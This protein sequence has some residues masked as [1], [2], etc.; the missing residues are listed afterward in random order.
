MLSVYMQSVA[1]WRDEPYALH[2]RRLAPNE[3]YASRRD[4]INKVL[5]RTT[6][7][8]GAPLLDVATTP[9]LR[10]EN[11]LIESVEHRATADEAIDVYTLRK[12]QILGTSIFVIYGDNTPLSLEFENAKTTG[13]YLGTISTAPDFQDF[14]LVEVDNLLIISRATYYR[15]WTSIY[16]VVNKFRDVEKVRDYQGDAITFIDN[17]VI[18]VEDLLW[19]YT[20]TSEVLAHESE[21]WVGMRSPVRLLSSDGRFVDDNFVGATLT[22][23]IIQPHVSM[24]L[25]FSEPP[26]ID[27]NTVLIVETKKTVRS[28]RCVVPRDCTSIGMPASGEY[29]GLVVRV[30]LTDSTLTQLDILAF[31]FPF[32]TPINGATS[33]LTMPATLNLDFVFDDDLEQSDIAASLARHARKQ[34]IEGENEEMPPIPREPVAVRPIG[35]PLSKFNLHWGVHNIDMDGGLFSGSKLVLDRPLAALLPAKKK[36]R[37]HVSYVLDRQPHKHRLKFKMSDAEE[38]RSHV[39]ELPGP[40]RLHLITAPADDGYLV[41]TVI[42]D[43]LREYSAPIAASS[44]A[45]SDHDS[46]E[47]SNLLSED[48]WAS[49]L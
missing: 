41:Q 26:T 46:S 49:F 33:L 48:D 34:W 13:V 16:S 12:G 36:V 1:Q 11:G 15:E 44:T 23:R 24:T 43:T 14:V 5:A 35:W 31:D 28:V 29:S 21:L 45:I 18:T 8:R 42:V 9:E 47:S 37:M 38:V 20:A 7:L 32:R 4:T 6:L 30:H 17:N 27:E 10:F 19:H 40:L 25:T 2:Q 39:F 3:F 22:T